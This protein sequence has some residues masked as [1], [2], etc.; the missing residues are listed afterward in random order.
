MK[1][2]LLVGEDVL[3]CALGKK[4]IEAALP[5]WSISGLPIDKKG[6][7]RLLPELPRYAECARHVRPVLCIAD[8]DNK[9]P[10]EIR[11]QWLPPE[12]PQE[13]LFRLAVS[14]AESWILADRHAVAQFFDV[15]LGVVPKAP[16]SIKDPKSE[17][18][19]IAGRSRKKSIRSEMLT[20]GQ[21]VRPGP[22][23]NVHLGAL[24]AQAW[25][26]VRAQEN[27]PSLR[28]AVINVQSL[29]A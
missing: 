4:I 29:S 6:I 25:D 21:Q 10:V 11:K 23:Y 1:D 26:V 22:G 17:M 8:T 5:D 3:C 7:T 28:R 18:L 9:C 2:I 20:A 13:L 27:C 16:E 12:A 14:E 24:I 19:K 15:P